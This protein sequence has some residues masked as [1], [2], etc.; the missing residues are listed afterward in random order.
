MTE[1]P[2]KWEDRKVVVKGW[3]GDRWLSELFPFSMGPSPAPFSFRAN[4]V[5]EEYEDGSALI[6][7]IS[8]DGSY[9]V[10]DRITARGNQLYKVIYEYK[11]RQAIVPAGKWRR[12]REAE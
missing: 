11:L 1:K 10:R 3:N 6:E 8:R 7:V 12:I 5:L 9:R 2:T 4:K